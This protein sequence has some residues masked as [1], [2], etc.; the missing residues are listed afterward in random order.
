MPQKLTPAQR[1]LV[2]NN[3][4]LVSFI[5]SQLPADYRDMVG[6]WDDLVQIGSMGLM[7]A[8]SR[9]NPSKGKF[10]TYASRAIISRIHRAHYL[11]NMHKRVANRSPLR[12]DAPMTKALVDADYT[13]S[14]WVD[15]LPSDRDETEDAIVRLTV[16][17]L[18][19]LAIKYD[20]LDT[21]N[22]MYRIACGETRKEI[23]QEYPYSHQRLAQ[24]TERGRQRLVMLYN[25]VAP[26]LEA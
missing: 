9:Y 6:E 17:E 14:S 20:L 11:N 13:I 24:R 16:D 18:R 10:S 8:A 5:L 12:L 23:A 19:Q 26:P 7:E 1:V 22:V 3:L 15:V 25:R 2:E 4:P 21:F